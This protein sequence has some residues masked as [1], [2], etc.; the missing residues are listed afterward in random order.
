VA[1]GS[2]GGDRSAPQRDSGR[3]HVHLQPRRARTALLAA[4]LHVIFDEARGRGFPA[5]KCAGRPA[6]GRRCSLRARA[7]A[8]RRGVFRAG[9]DPSCARLLGRAARRRRVRNWPQ[10]R[11]ARHAH[12]VPGAL[13]HDGVWL[14]AAR[15]GCLP[16][17]STSC[18]RP[19]RRRRSRKRPIRPGATARARARGLRNTAAGLPTAA[20]PDEILLE[21]DGRVRALFCLGGNPMLAFRP[22]PHR[23]RA[24]RARPAGRVRSRASATA[25]RALRDRARLTLETPGM[26][27]AAELLV[28]RSLVR[29]PP[30]CA[31]RARGSAPPAGSD[32]IEEWSSSTRWRDSSAPLSWWASTAG[33]ATSRAARDRAARHGAT[34]QHGRAVMVPHHRLARVARRRSAI[35]T[36]TSS[37]KVRRRTSARPRRDARLEPGILTCCASR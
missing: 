34:A 16:R 24:A 33:A 19:S 7:V 20:L 3:A 35:R 37:R 31:V 32:L 17:G 30:L 6:L 9:P 21:G 12:R 29:R 18:C 36:G 8:Q 1:R 10:L 5:G 2:A 14:L 13:S 25:A 28:L 11:D 27:Q 15:R 4:M 26:T 22:A 23:G